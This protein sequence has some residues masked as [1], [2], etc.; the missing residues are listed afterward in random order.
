MD[1]AKKSKYRSFRIIYLA[2][3]SFQIFG[4]KGLIRKIFRN[5]ELAP[6][7]RCKWLWGSFEVCLGG[8]THLETAP[9]KFLLSRSVGCKSI[10]FGH[11]RNVSRWES[12]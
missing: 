1:V 3:K 6:K 8:R 4:S 10:N 5:K 11:G 2:K 7:T 12:W 9:T